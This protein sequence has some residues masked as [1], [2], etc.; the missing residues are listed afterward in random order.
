MNI[1]EGRKTVATNYRIIEFPPLFS[2]DLQ[3]GLR[4]TNFNVRE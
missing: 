1:F 3:N 4:F 2:Y